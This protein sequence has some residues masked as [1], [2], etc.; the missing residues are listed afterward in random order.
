MFFGVYAQS[1]ATLS[2][3]QHDDKKRLKAVAKMYFI[4]GPTWIV[5]VIGWYLSFHTKV[6]QYK[7]SQ[8]GLFFDV[9]NALQV[10]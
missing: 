1:S 3:Q 10:S 9:I 5:E 7:A 4:M 8:F 2:I 6:G